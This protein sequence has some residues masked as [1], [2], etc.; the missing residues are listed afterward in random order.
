MRAVLTEFLREVRTAGIPVS[1]AE[2]IDALRAAATVGVVRE[3]LRDGLAAAIDA[4]TADLAERRSDQRAAD[5]SPSTSS[6]ATRSS[7]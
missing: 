2:S 3:R 1:L 6:G 7:V 5:R 4:I